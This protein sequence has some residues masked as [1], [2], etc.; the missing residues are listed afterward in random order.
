MLNPKKR[1]SFKKKSSSNRTRIARTE[2]ITSKPMEPAIAKN[3]PDETIEEIIEEEKAM[4]EETVQDENAAVSEVRADERP[5]AEDEE[6]FSDIE[7]LSREPGQGAVLAAIAAD[8]VVIAATIA[9]GAAAIDVLPDAA[10]TAA[11]TGGQGDA[12]AVSASRRR[13]A[14]HGPAQAPHRGHLQARPG[15]PRAGHQGRHRH[16]GPDAQHLHQHR[17]PLSRA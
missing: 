6:D 4:E 8:A 7:Y 1:S 12:P 10:A 17:R 5:L 9:A 13:Q 11:A 14:R 2:E 3:D 15:S 16:Q